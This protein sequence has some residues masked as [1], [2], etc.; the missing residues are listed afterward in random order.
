MEEGRSIELRRELHELMRPLRSEGEMDVIN[1]LL[2]HPQATAMIQA[3]HAEELHQLLFRFGRN[4]CVD[5]LRYVTEDQFHGLLDLDA[6]TADRLLPE[7]IDSMILL[8]NQASLE[9]LGE[10]FEGMD[11]ETLGVYLLRKA[12]FIARTFEPEQDDELPTD[13]EVFTSPD[14]MF[15][16]ITPPD[17]DDGIMIRMVLE[18]LYYLDRDRIGSILRTLHFEDADVLEHDANGLRT[19]R[20]S[21]YG[22][23]SLE[24]AE[25]LYLFVNPVRAKQRILQRLN[26]LPPQPLDTD[27]LLPVLFDHDKH[28]PAFLAKAIEQLD[29][30][31]ARQQLGFGVASLINH[32]IVREARGDL[33]D[34][35]GRQ[36]AVMRALGVYNLG[37]DF[38]SSG[39]L[40]IASKVLPRVLP[41]TLFRIGLSLTLLLRAR[42]RKLMELGGAAYGFLLFDPPLDDLVRGAA[43]DV[44]QFFEGLLDEDQARWRDFQTY[45]EY[46]TLRSALKQAEGVAD[47]VQRTLH[48]RLEELAASVPEDLRPAVTH[49]TLLATTLVNVLL[50]NERLLAP[51]PKQRFPQV[52]NVLLVT[53]EKGDR[54]V[55]PVFKASLDRFLNTEENRFAVSLV[56]LSLQK[57][58]TV[59]L[60]LPRDTIPEPEML[61]GV[62]LMGGRKDSR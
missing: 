15:Y 7:R 25:E 61:A 36:A 16:V 22:F 46:R 62:V 58:E 11:D 40:T 43:L 8:A 60:R 9:T 19:G 31:S 27:S 3:M 41:R 37:L 26:D 54:V 34:E 52:M 44:P 48:P 53:D 4:E 33:A 10:L 35:E 17:T 14:N 49:T 51:I 55:N 42:A 21:S 13:M 24:E 12:R 5:I 29:N 56:E 59:F 18:K 39:D 47:F 6:W 20:L 50:G 28:Q 30:D 23:P 45:A 57:L 38:V 1:R 32:V 2:D